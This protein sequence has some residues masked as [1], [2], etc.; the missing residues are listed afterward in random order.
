MY[1]KQLETFLK[2]ART[3]SFSRAA[4]AMYV[5]PSA[6]IQQINNLE[7]D[8]SVSLFRRSRQGV[9]LTEAGAYLAEEAGSYIQRGN[10]I[11][12][13]LLSIESHCST[14]CVGTAHYQK[15]RLLHDF[16]LTFTSS[17]N[18]YNIRLVNIQ[19][20]ST[21]EGEAELIESVKDDAPW[22]VWWEFMKVCDVPVGC[23]VEGHC[24]L[25]QRE[26]LRFEDLKGWTV[27]Y[28]SYP[29]AEPPSDVCGDLRACGIDVKG[30]EEYD[31][32]LMWKCACEPCALLAPLCW[33][34]IMT[35]MRILPLEKDYRME[36]GFFYRSDISAPV[37]EFLDYVK[38]QCAGQLVKL[39]A[40]YIMD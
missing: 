9:E 21:A 3:G 32:N 15:V 14:I 26:V 34:D 29:G 11:R 12:R 33:Q 39:S 37:K 38:K 17:G 40:P 10:Q 6:V 8:L 30:A 27:F 2:V 36:Y 28:H 24:A 18:G 19:S 5:S 23:A 35:D 31:M 1:N 22:Q 7:Q 20:G 16:W 4:A 13:R 25:A